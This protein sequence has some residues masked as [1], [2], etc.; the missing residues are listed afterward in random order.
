MK[1]DLD[2]MRE[3]LLTTEASEGPIYLPLI[4]EPPRPP[5]DIALQV[6]LLQ[7][8]GYIRA[9]ISP[10]RE[11]LDIAGAII[12]ITNSGYDYLDTV[13]HPKVWSETKSVLEKIGGSAALEVVK[14]IAAKFMADLIR[15]YLGGA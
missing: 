5:G 10:I 9:E 12:R 3:L 1:R 14:D 4:S 6:Q 15:P 7:D 8:A 2:L 11:S 13:R